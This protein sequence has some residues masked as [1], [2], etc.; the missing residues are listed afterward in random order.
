MK[1]TCDVIRDLLPLYKE[2]MLS[3]DSKQ[4]IEEHLKK[5]PE[6][7][8]EFQDISTEMNV[9]I[10]NSITPLR[11]IQNQLTKRYTQIA[12][13]F[14]L[15]SLIF[16]LGLVA[17]LTTPN[18]LPY[19]TDLVTIHDRDGV[20]VEF[21]QSIAGYEVTKRL[22]NEDSGEVYTIMAWQTT[23]NE[24]FPTDKV[25]NVAINPS[26][27]N[28]PHIYYIQGDSGENR[29]VYGENQNKSGGSFTLPRLF[30]A[31]YF[32]ISVI[33]SLISCILFL[34]TKNNYLKYLLLISVSYFLSHLLI[35]G[36]DMSTFSAFRDL[37]MI[38]LTSFPI[39]G[40]FLFASYKIKNRSSHK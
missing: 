14:S 13:L 30:L 26:G 12:V 19:E 31:Y 40:L 2:D 7:Q 5:C 34:L 27:E 23:W 25:K 39:F 38:V 11:K 18:Y 6:C 37:S 15:I 32:W 20:L 16:S 35:K 22:S 1:V 28:I 9:P 24:L 3:Q 21:N 29:L 36:W 33:V 17:F 4:L 10:E 8:M